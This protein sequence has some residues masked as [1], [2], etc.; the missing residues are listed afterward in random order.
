M[1]V[2]NNISKI[3]NE[4]RVVFGLNFTSLCVWKSAH[5]FNRTADALILIPF[6][7][8]HVETNYSNQSNY[9]ITQQQSFF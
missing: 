2:C 4:L 5:I 9:N 8:Y 3:L 1:I 6:P 7:K